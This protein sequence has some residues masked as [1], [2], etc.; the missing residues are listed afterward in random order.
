MRRSFLTIAV[1]TLALLAGA[2]DAQAKTEIQFW[3]AMDGQLGEAVDALVK[4]F[5][6]SQGEVE[7]KAVHKG[8]YPEVLA[9]VM[10][11]YRQKN[12]PHIA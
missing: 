8:T 5:N 3:H 4:Q 2:A 11:A 6:Q 12:P 7:V 9:A 1:V 10:A